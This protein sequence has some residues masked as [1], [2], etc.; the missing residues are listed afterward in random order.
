MFYLIICITH[1]C[2]LYLSCIINYSIKCY[3]I[4]VRA[5]CD[6]KFVYNDNDNDKSL[7]SHNIRVNNQ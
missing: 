7:F 5:D 6:K 4:S 2:V 3:V 1:H